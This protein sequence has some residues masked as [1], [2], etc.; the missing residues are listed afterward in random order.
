MCKTRT[1]IGFNEL[2]LF[3]CFKKGTSLTLFSTYSESSNLALSIT[4]VPHIFGFALLFRENDALLLDISDPFNPRYIKKINLVFLSEVAKY[5]NEPSIGL[6]VNDE[7]ISARAL[8]E[9]RDSRKHAPTSVDS[10]D[11]ST[12]ERVCAW[13]WEPVE[14]GSSKLII[15]LNTGALYTLDIHLENDR[16][17]IIPYGPLFHEFPCNALLWIRGGFIA[18]FGEMGDGNILKLENGKVCSLSVIEN[19]APILDMSFLDYHE[20]NRDQMFACSGVCSEGSLRTV[21][22]GINVEKLTST[23]PTYIGVTGLWTL[24]MK[25][26]DHY[27]SFLVL[28]FVEETRVLSVG[29]QFCDISDSVGFR[30]NVCTLAC[31]LL[32]DGMLVQIH[33]TE[34]R[35]CLPTVKAHLAGIYQS[36][37]IIKSWYPDAMSISHGTV[38]N[39]HIII[40]TTNPFCLSI[41]AVN[42]MLMSDFE[43]YKLHNFELHDEVSCISIPNTSSK[44]EKL[45]TLSIKNRMDALSRVKIND[46]FVIGTHKPSVNILSYT[47]KEGIK[48]IAVGDILIDNYPDD[49]FI[50]CIPEDIRFVLVDRCYVLSG[51]RNGMLLRFEFPGDVLPSLSATHTPIFNNHFSRMDISIP[52]GS[53]P[54]SVYMESS[55]IISNGNSIP[56]KLQLVALRHIGLTPVFLVPLQNSLDSDLIVLSD[57]PWLLQ[58]ARHNL[59]FTSISFGPATHVTSV[60]NTDFHKGILFIAENRLHLVRIQISIFRF[61]FPQTNLVQRC[62]QI[63]LLMFMRLFV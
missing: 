53:P 41:L 27:H 1:N 15:S 40:A 60:S 7:D 10:T 59:V 32:I 33:R 55:T 28:S 12:I 46:I 17:Q 30:C 34:V 8:L 38:G 37:P 4:D 14:S 9:L 49:P 36:T 16:V 42:S 56:V 29:M 31:G 25:A 44:D 63:D 58:S 61:F 23:P 54:S 24:H 39:N 48:V 20:E 5:I 50:G 35:V 21:R 6:C 2:Y 11:V 47:P 57:R 22:S 3:S 43:I 18:V 19:M 26:T 13:S 52:C 62:N 51:L 45:M